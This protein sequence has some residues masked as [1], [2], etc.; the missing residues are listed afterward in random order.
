MRILK[1]KALGCIRNML[2]SSFYLRCLFEILL[3]SLH[4]RF[5]SS[6]FVRKYRHAYLHPRDLFTN[7]KRFCSCFVQSDSIV[8]WCVETAGVLVVTTAVEQWKNNNHIRKWQ[9]KWLLL[10]IHE[11][12]KV[13]HAKSILCVYVRWLFSSFLWRLQH[14]QCQRN[15]TRWTFK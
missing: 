13:V 6:I 3:W 7:V 9:L 5:F 15:T 14:K 10:Y 12:L 4:C 1:H 2:M 11:M 8:M